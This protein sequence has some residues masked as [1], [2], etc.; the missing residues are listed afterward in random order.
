MNKPL[1]SIHYE[2]RGVIWKLSSAFLEH[3]PFHD[4]N[5]VFVCIGTDRST[6]D[7]L[8]P[9]TGSFLS[10]YKSF[11]FPVVGTLE[12]PVHAL[13]LPTIVGQLDDSHTTGPV[14]AIDACLGHHY[15]I[16][17]ILLEK[18]PLWPGKAVQKELPA[19]GEYSIKVI[20]NHLHGDGI[21]TLQKT[22]L[23]HTQDLAR[24]VANALFLA[25]HRY[26]STL[27]TSKSHTQPQLTDL[28]AN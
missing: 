17:D 21:E 25:W 14:I 16:G 28:A 19:V 13:N 1:Y 2:Q 4:P 15:A 3:L 20:V 10:L 9:L 8:G 5:M 11:P 22:R 12:T 7:S 26:S 6:G 24:V 27:Q 23:L 18:G